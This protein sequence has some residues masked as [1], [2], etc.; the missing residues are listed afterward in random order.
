MDNNGNTHNGIHTTETTKHTKPSKGIQ[1]NTNKG[2][3]TK[4]TKEYKQRKTNEHTQCNPTE[5]K[6]I[7]RNTNT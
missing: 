2:I 6:G 1:R 4:E 7:H 5:Y 3:Q